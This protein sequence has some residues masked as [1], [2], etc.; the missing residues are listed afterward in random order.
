MTT[1]HVVDEISRRWGWAILRMNQESVRYMIGIVLHQNIEEIGHIAVEV[2]SVETS[3]CREERLQKPI[4]QTRLKARR[5]DEVSGNTRSTILLV[6]VVCFTHCT[7]GRKRP[8]HASI[9]KSLKRNSIPCLCRILPFIQYLQSS[10]NWE[11]APV[12]RVSL[13]TAHDTRR[14][15]ERVFVTSL[16]IQ[17]PSSC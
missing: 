13:Q 2:V 5:V 14:Y 7:V 16:H 8:H 3:L 10:L 15:Y 9:W 17:F 12:L 1:N 4:S 6:I 11:E